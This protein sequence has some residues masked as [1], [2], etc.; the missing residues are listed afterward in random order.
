MAP[1]H[2]KVKK[3]TNRRNRFSR[4]LFYFIATRWAIGRMFQEQR[5]RRGI[6]ARQMVRAQIRER[7]GGRELP[8]TV[9]VESES[10]DE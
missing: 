1:P 10:D 8:E 2:N 7:Y 9:E 5:L 6:R 3:F 4:G